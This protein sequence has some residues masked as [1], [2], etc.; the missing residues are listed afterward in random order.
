MTRR[1]A[2]QR[3]PLRRGVL[4]LSRGR[5]LVAARAPRR[6]PAR[7]RAVVARLS[8]RLDAAPRALQTAPATTPAAASSTTCRTPSRCPGT[9][10]APTSARATSSACCAPTRRAA[11]RRSFVV[12]CAYEIPLELL[13]IVMQREGWMRLGRWSYRDA[14]RAALRRPARARGSR[15]A[16]RLARLALLALLVPVDLLWTLPREIWRAA[17]QGRLAQFR[18]YLRGLWDG[19]ARPAAAAARARAAMTTASA[20]AVRRAGARHADCSPSASRS[21]RWP[22]EPDMRPDDLEQLKDDLIDFRAELEEPGVR[23]GLVETALPRILA[24]LEMIPDSYRDEDILELGSSPYFL[25]LCLYRL[26]TRHAEARQLLR[27]RRQARRRSAG[28]PAHRRGGRV[29]VRGLQHRDRRRFPTRT[30]ASTSSSSR[31]SSSTSAST[32]CARWRRSTASCGRAAS[33]SSRRRTRSRSSASARFVRGGSQMVDRYSPLFGYGARHNREYH[34]RELRELLEGTGFAIEEMATRDLAAAAAHRALAARALEAAA[35]ALRRRPARGAHLPARPPRRRASAGISRPTS[36]TTSSS[37][38]WSRYPWVEMGINDSIQCAAGWYPLER[39]RRRRRAALDRRRRGTGVSEDAGERS[40]RSAPRCSRR[41]RPARRPRALRVVVWDR[42]LGRV[43]RRERLRRR[44]R[45]RRA[46][47]LATDRAA[48]RAAASAPRRRGRGEDP[49]RRRPASAGGASPCGASGSD[50]AARRTESAA[51]RSAAMPFKQYVRAEIAAGLDETYR[52]ENWAADTP[53]RAYYDVHLSVI[54]ERETCVPTL[55]RVLAG[56]R[57]AHPRIGLRHRPLDGV[58]RAPRSPCR[59]ASTT[60]PGPLRVARA[61]DPALRL[62]RGDVVASPFKDASFDA[63]FSS[64]VAEHFETGPDALLREIRRVLKPDGLLLIVVPY[65][66]LFR[67]LVTNRVLQAFYLVSR[68]RG[69][70]S[71]SPSI[72]SRARRSTAFLARD[73]LSHRARRARRLPPAVG[74]GPQPRPR[75]ARPPRGRMGDL[76]AERRR[77]VLARAL[78]AISPWICAAGIFSSRAQS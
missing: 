37:T 51:L 63:V 39:R 46:R 77:H 26:C 58:L 31:S 72:A 32:R 62:V 61:R 11:E 76:G 59:S 30:R 10:C 9:R 73:R 18:S 53:G 3:R 23:A 71:P 40:P 69:R 75:P 27:P 14:A 2:A 15:D 52:F 42:W 33:S 22:F 24:T 28:E 20:F 34:P 65:N 25:S 21:A 55:R 5:R 66:N 54:D 35:G 67:R 8:P 4:R 45:D 12:S 41:P 17:R 68:L 7:L 29:R 13:A 43:R 6:L 47:R 36:S 78:N 1:G 56:A 70:P 64:Y 49:T 60:A 48:D 44:R 74:E 16:A 57:H 38:P 19:C 50:T